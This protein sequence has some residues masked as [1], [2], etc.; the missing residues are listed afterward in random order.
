MDHLHS[1]LSLRESSAV[2]CLDELQPLHSVLNRCGN[3]FEDATFA[4]RKATIISSQPIRK[5]MRGCSLPMVGI[6]P[7]VDSITWRNATFAGAK[8]DYLFL[9]AY[10]R[11]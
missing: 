1:R 7:L 11:E 9:T 5:S 10:L 2:F 6:N 8:G 4:E 3:S